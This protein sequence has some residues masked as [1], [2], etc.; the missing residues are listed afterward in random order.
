MDKELLEKEFS[1]CKDCPHWYSL[2]GECRPNWFLK[3]Q[4][5]DF[6][7]PK[8]VRRPQQEYVKE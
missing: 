6:E 2:T 1:P 8:N 5:T 3:G 7:C 4:K